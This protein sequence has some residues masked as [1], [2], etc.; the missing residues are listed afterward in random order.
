MSESSQQSRFQVIVKG[1]PTSVEDWKRVLSASPSEL[2]LTNEQ[3]AWAK[4]FVGWTE[5]DY[6]RSRLLHTYAEN[7]FGKRGV[8]LGTIVETM[9]EDLG[10]GYR[11]LALIYER[12]KPR[13]VV[14]VQK[15]ES[16]PVH[17][18]IPADLA[19][20]V[21]DSGTIQDQERLRELLVT[22]LRRSE[23]TSKTQTL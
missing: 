1:A 8:A 14:R 10:T 5:E 17:I 19:D 22:W 12:H 4:Q 6:A 16:A 18:A 7:R 9:L 21:V 11:L 2:Q 13:W 20:D 23:T 15:E 3:K